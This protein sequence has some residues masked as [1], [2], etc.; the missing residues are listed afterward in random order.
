MTALRHRDLQQLSR[1]LLYVHATRDAAEF[2]TQL[3]QAMRAAV[4]ADICVVDWNDAQRLGVQTAY[5]PLGAVP[6]EVNTAVHRHLQDNP[7]YGRR[8][9]TP[10]SIS[11]LLTRRQWH[12]T[13]L[14]TEAYGRLGQQDGLGLDIRFD[15]GCLVSLVTTRGRRGYSSSD[16][17]KLAALGAHV[18][19][20]YA[21]L[22]RERRIAVRPSIVLQRL[23][24]REREILAHAGNGS[25]NSEI[26]VLLGIRAGTVKRHLENAYHKLGVGNR[27]D[28][29]ELMR[30]EIVADS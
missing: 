6:A 8:K 28:A 18:R 29:V 3:L 30:S 5:D 2:S 16:R 26:A 25:R 22:D 1:A 10:V 12:A 11:D 17:A 21:R 7:L 15:D 14:Y 19:H 9:A 13:A 24:V 20:V 4:G 23:S 27:R